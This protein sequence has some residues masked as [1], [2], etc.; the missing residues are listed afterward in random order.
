VRVSNSSAFD[1][2]AEARF[3]SPILAWMIM[4]GE[5]ADMRTRSRL[6]SGGIELFV[7]GFTPRSEEVSGTGY[8]KISANAPLAR[9]CHHSSGR[10]SRRSTVGCADASDLHAN[11]GLADRDV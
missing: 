9:G 1:E 8:P 6:E 4:E 2:R 11:S 5:S 7:L 3:I 10:I